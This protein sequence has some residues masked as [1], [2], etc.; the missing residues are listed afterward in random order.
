MR[1]VAATTGALPLRCDV[2]DA[3]ATVAALKEAH[4]KNGAARILVNCAGIG[5]AKRIVGKDGPM[6]LSEF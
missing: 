6:A 5:A 2:A 1:D 4:D 3:D